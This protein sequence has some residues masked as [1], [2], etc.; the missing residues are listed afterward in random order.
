MMSNPQT[1]APKAAQTPGAEPMVKIS[2]LRK[3]YR[4]GSETVVALDNIDLEIARGE[5]CCILGTSG[6]GKSTLLN[7]IAGL[8]K[9]TRGSVQINSQNIEKMSERKLATFRQNNMGFVFQS[10]NLLPALTALENVSM[11]LTFRGIS[12][13]TRKRIAEKMLDRVG[14]AHRLKHKPGQMSGGQQQRVGIARAMVGRP[15]LVL[16]DEP[17]GNLDTRTTEEVMQM[18]VEM[19]RRYGLTLILVTHDREIADYA[20]R[21][22]HITD[23]NITSIKLND[24]SGDDA[25]AQGGQA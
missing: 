13:K 3:V 24:H 7:M 1:A 16:A 15:P 5:I 6:S 8:E 23:G 21:V 10:Y 17:T 14:L 11:P 19:A 9:P 25:P 4:I 20:D 18:I 2:S 22:V 12:G